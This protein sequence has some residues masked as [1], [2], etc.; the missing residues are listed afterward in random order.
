M[1]NIG[2]RYAYGFTLVEI[3]VSLMI[4]GFIIVGITAVTRPLLRE[5]RMAV[6][7][8]N[9]TH[10]INALSAYTQRN[11]RIPCPAN[12]DVSDIS[13]PLGAEVGSGV[14]GGS[15]PVVTPPNGCAKSGLPFN[16][17]I[18]PFKTLGLS[19]EDVKDGWRNYLTYH[20]NPSYAR[21]TTQV[22][23]NVHGKCRLRM[24]TAENPVAE[25]WINYVGPGQNVNP[26][27]ARFC[28]G[29]TAMNTPTDHEITINDASGEPLFYYV[30]DTLG[31]DYKPV[32]TVFDGYGQVFDQARNNVTSTAVVLISH[33]DNGSGAFRD[34]GARL[35][36]SLGMSDMEKENADGDNVFATAPR[37]LVTMT[38]ALYYDDVIVSR[39]QDQIYAETGTSSCALP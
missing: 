19:P 5:S 16:E 31:T 7:Q 26:P 18:V 13:Q 21:D 9:M 39:T 4:V 6:T 11:N 23:I 12:P 32:D 35:P 24:G 38:G 2:S 10:V 29:D 22:S 14:A 17:G 25:D 33:G 36:D 30:R 27:R 1:N 37:S 3:A 15:I 8:T 34:N 28:C 20:V